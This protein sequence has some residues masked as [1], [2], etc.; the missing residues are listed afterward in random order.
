MHNLIQDDVRIREPLPNHKRPARSKVA[1]LQMLLHS[2]EEIRALFLAVGGVF[3]FFVGGKEGGYKKSAPCRVSALYFLPCAPHH[4]DADRAAK[5]E[6]TVDDD[7]ANLVCEIL[8]LVCRAVVCS[9]EQPRHVSQDRV[10]LRQDL[11]VE[12]DDGDRGRGV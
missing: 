12:F 5:G 10:A 3:G 1:R 11:S 9:A 7:V 4:A 2:R 8:L 6:H